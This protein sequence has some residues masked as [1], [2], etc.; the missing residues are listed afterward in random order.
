[1]G[2]V[3]TAAFRRERRVVPAENEFESGSEEIQG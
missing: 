3:V 2:V 1:V